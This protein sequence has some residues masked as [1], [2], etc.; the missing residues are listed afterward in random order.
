MVQLWQ[1]MRTQT[2]AY[3]EEGFHVTDEDTEALYASFLEKESPRSLDELAVQIVKRHCQAERTKLEKETARGQLYRP[4]A[5]YQVGQELVFSPLDYQVGRVVSIRPGKN[6]RY[7][8]FQVIEVKLEGEEETREFAAQFAESHSLTVITVE[9]EAGESELEPEQIYQLYG[10]PI[11]RKVAYALGTDPELV[12]LDGQWFLRSLLPEVHVGYLNIA[13]A[14]IHVAD[15]PLKASELLVEMDLPNEASK[16]AKSMALELALADD[17]RF[18]ELVVDGERA[19][20]LYSLEPEA[21][22]TVPW[23]LELAYPRQPEELLLGELLEF[24]REIGDEWDEP[25]DHVLP[26]KPSQS[27]AF[28]LGFPHWREGTLP[29]TGEIRAMLPQNAGDR[30]PFRLLVDD[31]PMGGW[32]LMKERYA[33]GLGSWYRDQEIS[34]GS[35]LTVKRTDDP[36][37]LEVGFERRPRRGEWI[38]EA[39]VVD[40]LLTFEMQRRAYTTRYD[41]TLVVHVE[42]VE[43]L[44]ELAR[45]LNEREAPLFEI[46]LDIVPELI[47]LSSNSVFHAKTLYAAVNLIR[48][49]GAVPIFAELTRHACFDPVGA[50]NWAFDPDL[51]DVIYGTE[52]EMRDRP[53]SQQ[54]ELLRDIVVPV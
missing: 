32:A 24:V 31:Q 18:D 45:G 4:E 48:R 6:P 26:D 19:W 14:M 43:P 37:T 13:E 20:F 7:Q 21:A 44:D 50:G 9:A 47:K 54:A 40:G 27:A 51:K 41:R 23:R 8:P 36:W 53:Q 49:S 17:E 12:H 28:L 52:E 16:A 30:F 38:K 46:M 39:A 35:T 15:R 2:E 29:L 34:V 3:W 1:R 5:E 10:G 33:C 42:D 11:R 25:Q 22:V